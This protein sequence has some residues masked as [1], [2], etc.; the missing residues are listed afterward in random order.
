MLYFIYKLGRQLVLKPS[1]RTCY[2]IAI[3]SADIYYFFA[4]EDRRHLKENLKI[5]LKT[6]DQKLLNKYVKNVFRN[7]A[8]YLVDFFRF[9]KLSGSYI[10]SH[11]KIE[12][13]EKI[14]K[15][16]AAGKGAVILSAHFGNWELA[17][18]VV[19]SLGYPLHV[20]ALDHKDK[21]INNFFLEQR[22]CVNMKVIPIGA[23]LKNCFK[24]L[25]K[26]KFLAILGDKDFSNNGIS[27]EFFGRSCLLPKGPAFFSLRTGAPIIPCFM[28]RNEDDTFR[29]VFGDPI[30][31]TKSGDKEADIKSLMQRYVAVIE[32][33]VKEF[34]DQ[35]Y[36][37]RK[38]WE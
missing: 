27:T 30:E 31:H 13:K 38:V 24:V 23:Q 6:E 3:V 36:V 19:G 14:D 10:M 25:R 28:I 26:N 37:F 1:L 7:F 15:A 8:K 12:G 21:R 5:V 32:K 18:A 35:W 34:P 2:K 33:Y 11:V 22:A 17:G 9:S 4:R 16:M 20:I 29:L